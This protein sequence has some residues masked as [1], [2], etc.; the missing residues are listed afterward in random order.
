MATVD[1]SIEVN[2]PVRTA[3]N[4]WTQ[5]ELFPRFMEGVKEVRQIDDSHLHWEVSLAGHAKE[6]DAEIN[7]QIPDQIIQ[8]RST[9]GD[10]NG[11]TVRFD[12]LAAS[13]TRVR[14][15]MHYEPDGVVESAGSA[16][17]VFS[18]RIEGDL[19]RFKAFVEELGTETG[20]YRDTIAPHGR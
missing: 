1:K 12:S 6:W 16:L 2:V 11:G 14:L 9:S 13:Q 7:E 3:Y 10:K 8:W 18:K 17:G 20:G 4:Q 5:F 15:T 19:G